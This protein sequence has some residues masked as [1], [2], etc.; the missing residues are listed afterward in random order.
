MYFQDDP[1]KDFDS[2]SE[3]IKD[4]RRKQNIWMARMG[5]IAL[6]KCDE[7]PLIVFEDYYELD[8]ITKVRDELLYHFCSLHDAEQKAKEKARIRMKI[9]KRERLGK[10]S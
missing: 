8:Q 10:F 2:D 4:F 9:N 3:L 1:E 6:E 7:T 5:I